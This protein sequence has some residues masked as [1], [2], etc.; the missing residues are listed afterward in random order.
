MTRPLYE[1]TADLHRLN[2]L[3]EDIE[4]DLSRLGEMEP[5]VTAWF[6]A[7]AGEQAGK[8]DGYLNLIR[9][10]DMEASAARAEKEQWAAKEKART[11]RTD[12]LKA[13][14]KAHLEATNQPK[15]QTASGRVI[16]IQRNGGVQPLEIKP[17]VTVA[18]VPADYHKVTVDFDRAAIR[19]ALEAGEGLAFAELLPRGTSLRIR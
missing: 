10:L 14:L 9:Q 6:D 7:L 16:S 18:D 5:A 1:I 15:V 8:L 2:D 11:S 19:A 3:L 17:G 13:K 4:G 12:Y